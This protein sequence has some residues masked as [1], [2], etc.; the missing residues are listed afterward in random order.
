MVPVFFAIAS[1]YL[2]TVNGRHVF[3]PSLFG[4]VLSLWFADGMISASP[5]YQ[6]GG[7]LA[8]AIF[9]V[10]AALVLFVFKIQRTTLILSFLV[11]YFVALAFRAWLTRWHMPPETLFMGALTSPA[12]YLFAFFMI[13]DPVTSPKGKPGQVMMALAI[14]VIDL[15]L[16]KVQV[17]STLFYAG[18]SY[19]FLRYI[20]LILT[21][22]D[23][24]SGRWAPAL[25][26]SLYRWTILSGVTM[27]ALI[28]YKAVAI[29]HKANN[30]S[31]IEFIEVD[32]DRAGISSRPSDLLN[33]VD[34]RLRHIGKWI[35]SVGDS[36]AINDVNED[37]LMDI[38]L[39]NSMKH[40]SDRVALYLNKVHFSLSV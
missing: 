16:H 17:Y 8:V 34:P 36:V 5:A 29:P 26:S 25:K 35:L 30:I 20:W 21:R 3:N 22:A 23:I 27:A 7:S 24:V 19:F 38:F 4:I 31:D 10:T 2:L 32:S 33:R 13:T 9:I 12:F 37:G 1:K 11:F 28:T 18:F 14:V 39:T 15:L 6:W 40:A